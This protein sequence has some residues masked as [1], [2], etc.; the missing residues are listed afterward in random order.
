VLLLF[1]PLLICRLMVTIFYHLDN[2][3]VHLLTV[4]TSHV[5]A[6]CTT[7]LPGFVLSCVAGPSSSFRI[8]LTAGFVS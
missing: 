8:W 3:L 4:S 6:S 7:H 2:L 1:L 5:F